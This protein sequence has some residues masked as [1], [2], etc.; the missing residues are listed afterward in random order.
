MREVVFEIFFG[1]VRIDDFEGFALLQQ[2]L[3]NLVELFRQ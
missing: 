1:I 3:G 2:S